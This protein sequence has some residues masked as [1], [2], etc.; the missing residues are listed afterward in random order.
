M[1]GKLM[2]VNN[3]VFYFLNGLGHRYDALV[4]LALEPPL[5]TLKTIIQMVYSYELCNKDN[6]VFSSEMAMVTSRGCGRSVR[7]RTYTS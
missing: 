5:P 3:L 7:G 2:F 1:I 4:T 6:Q